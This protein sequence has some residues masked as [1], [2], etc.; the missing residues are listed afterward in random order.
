VHV[1]FSRDGQSLASVGSDGT[2]LV[3]E[4][5]TLIQKPAP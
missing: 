1:A 5:G 4:A 3:W 2:V